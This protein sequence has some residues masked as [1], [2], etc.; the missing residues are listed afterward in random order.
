M[1]LK[2]RIDIAAGRKKAPLVLKNCQIINVFTEEILSG[3]IAID[4]DTIAGIGVY[5]GEEEK[6]MEGRFVAPGLID[7]HVHIESSMV[8]PGQFARAIVPRGTTTI[9]ADPHEIANVCGLEGIRYILEESEGLPLNVYVM[10]PSCVPATS[11]ENSGAIL[12]AAALK[13]L[14]GHPRV[15]GLGELMDY[16][17]VI[18][19]EKM[20]LDK[21]QIAKDKFIDGH[22][23]GITG[24]ALNAYVMAGTKTEH[25]CSTQGEM[26]ERLRLGMYI[27]IREGSAA[28]NL[29]N[30][31]RGVTKENLR[32]CLFCTDDRHPEDILV[33]G[34]IDNNIRTAIKNGFSPI[35]AIRMATLNAAECYGLKTLGAVA[36]GYRA[37]L[38][39]IDDLQQF[40]V[41]EVYKEGKKVAENGRALF[42]VETRYN[43]AV[44]NTVNIGK[45][46]KE[47]LEILVASD[48]AHVIKILPHSLLTEK[49][50]RKIE[51]EEG[52]FKFH[53]RL[54]ILK[55]AVIERHRATGNI[56]LA[57]VEDFKLKNG[58]IASTVAHDSHNLVVIGDND[59]DMMT[60]IEEI[61]R[62]GGGITIC[63][64]G[65]V[66]KTLPLPIAGLISDQTIEEVDAQLKEMMEMA[67]KLGVNGDIDPF[68]TLSFL[69]LPVIPSVKV[70]DMGLFDVDIFDFIELSIKE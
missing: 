33:N 19:G 46:T 6:D 53:N 51:T 27:Q 4:G 62:C 56:G 28:R 18:R 23:P 49:V 45:V 20:V 9:I 54:D 70:T 64:K 67:R 37:D 58:A 60:A 41:V 34:H 66:L 48:I 68:M 63:S 24:H 59:G 30:L 8:T 55:M 35:S 52:K 3:D 12:D 65:K 69:A 1:T 26:L 16:P 43:S 44:L 13:Q 38:I 47:K 17:A 14:I 25:E 36:P 42:Q 31:I 32:R 29:E 15:L 10:L 39:I 7:G 50:I 57:L 40:N 11:F 22:G 61:E 2:D 21:I 5:E